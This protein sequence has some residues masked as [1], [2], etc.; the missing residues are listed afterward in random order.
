M[1]RFPK[2]GF[3]RLVF[4]ASSKLSE[5]DIKRTLNIFISDKE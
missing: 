5:Q 3:V 4:F 1:N 2:I